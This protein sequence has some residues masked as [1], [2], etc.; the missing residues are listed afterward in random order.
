VSADH[1]RDGFRAQDEQDAED[2]G[3]E[4]EEE[5]DDEDDEDEGEG[6]G[7]AVSLYGERSEAGFLIWA[8]QSLTALL[9][10]DVS[11]CV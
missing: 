4:D 7:G 6:N 8:Q 10:G 5:D 1:A 2:G 9:L 3:Y 11:T